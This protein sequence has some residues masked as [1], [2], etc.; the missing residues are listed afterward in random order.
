MPR[1]I[2]IK[3]GDGEEHHLF[4]LLQILKITEIF[5]AGLFLKSSIFCVFEFVVVPIV[6]YILNI[7][8]SIYKVTKNNKI[9]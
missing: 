5:Q 9:S 4:D 1:F 7:K 6:L 8:M 2:I 3:H